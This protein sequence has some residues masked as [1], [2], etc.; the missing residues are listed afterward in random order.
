MSLTRYYAATATGDESGVDANNAALITAFNNDVTFVYLNGGD[1]FTLTNDAINSRIAI[2][3]IRLYG[4]GTGTP[5]L[6]ITG[7]EVTGGIIRV[8]TGGVSIILDDGT[9]FGPNMTVDIGSAG[10]LRPAT[11]T[12][13]LVTAAGAA[14]FNFNHTSGTLGPMGELVDGHDATTAPPTVEKCSLGAFVTVETKTLSV[15]SN[16]DASISATVNGNTT[17]SE[18]LVLG[19]NSTCNANVNNAAESTFSIARI[20]GNAT[21][22]LNARFSVSVGNS[23]VAAVA[24]TPFITLSGDRTIPLDLEASD[25]NGKYTGVFCHWPNLDFSL[26]DSTAQIFQ[27]TTLGAAAFSRAR[28]DAF[29]K[30]GH[31]ADQKLKKVGG[32]NADDEA[33]TWGYQMVMAHG[34]PGTTVQRQATFAVDDAYSVLSGIWEHVRDLDGSDP[35]VEN[36]TGASE[37]ALFG[38]SQTAASSVVWPANMI[39]YPMEVTVSFEAQGFSTG[40]YDYDVLV[41]VEGANVSEI[42]GSSAYRIPVH[43]TQTFDISAPTDGGDGVPTAS[44]DLTGNTGFTAAGDDGFTAS[45]AENTAHSIAYEVTQSSNLLADSYEVVLASTATGKTAGRGAATVSNGL[46]GTLVQTGDTGSFAISAYND[47]YDDGSATDDAV[48]RSFSL[49]LKLKDTFGGDVLSVRNV[50]VNYTD[51]DGFAPNYKR[52]GAVAD[53]PGVSTFTGEEPF[54]NALTDYDTTLGYRVMPLLNAGF[55]GTAAPTSIKWVRRDD[56]SEA[57]YGA[58]SK[59][60][61]QGTDTSKPVVFGTYWRPAHAVA[62]ASTAPKAHGYVQVGVQV[63]GFGT[64][65]AIGWRP[66]SIRVLSV[67]NTDPADPTDPAD[68][69][70]DAG[71]FTSANDWIQKAD[72][73]AFTRTDFTGSASA[74]GHSARVQFR[75]PANTDLSAYYLVLFEM[76]ATDAAGVAQTWDA[77]TGQKSGNLRVWIEAVEDANDQLAAYDFD[78]VAPKTF[79]WHVQPNIFVSQFQIDG[80]S[81]TLRY[82]L[83]NYTKNTAALAA[84]NDSTNLITLA[85]EESWPEIAT[86]LSSA[87]Q[88]VKFGYR[89]I[90]HGFANPTIHTFIETKSEANVL[91][92]TVSALTSAN[93]DVTQ[94]GVSWPVANDVFGSAEDGDTSDNWATRTSFDTSGDYKVATYTIPS[95]ALRRPKAEFTL[96][97]RTADHTIGVDSYTEKSSWAAQFTVVTNVGAGVLSRADRPDASY[98]GGAVTGNASLNTGAVAVRNTDV[99]PRFQFRLNGHPLTNG[100]PSDGNNGA[101]TFKLYV[102]TTA[103]STTS[104]APSGAQTLTLNEEAVIKTNSGDIRLA[105]GNDDWE[106]KADY[107]TDLVSDAVQITSANYTSYV[108]AGLDLTGMTGTLPS[109]LQ[110]WLVAQGIP[111]N[112]PYARPGVSGST[113]IE[114]STATDTFYNGWKVAEY[115]LTGLTHAVEVGEWTALSRPNIGNDFRWIVEGDALSLQYATYKDGTYQWVT[116]SKYDPFSTNSLW[117]AGTATT[118]GRFAAQSATAT[119][120]VANSVGNVNGLAEHRARYRV[121]RTAT[122]NSGVW[123]MYNVEEPVIYIRGADD[124]YYKMLKASDQ[125]ALAGEVGV[126]RYLIVD[127][128]DANVHTA[129]P[130]SSV[131]AVGD[132]ASFDKEILTP[133]PQPASFEVAP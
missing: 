83:N 92:S 36:A 39:H 54:T 53:V 112:S 11:A 67:P 14:T 30:V 76:E 79:K 45:V 28:F 114:L 64:D 21:G 46:P 93:T 25:P 61:E 5:T 128:G 49:T 108:T 62:G 111:S 119:V 91:I 102:G 107:V 15:A 8:Y 124:V 68:L 101:V 48:Y 10:N 78:A 104:G 70:A 117:Q 35:P 106:E 32:D 51:D 98:D 77:T 105:T 65:A 55:D 89:G 131:S 127:S 121:R 94:D 110:V 123:D 29:Q 103:D 1:S 52:L 84:Q 3:N 90:G 120:A 73:V 12:S 88:T 33:S 17:T 7:G 60:E 59:G 4:F 43:I 100:T 130:W 22:G 115:D 113:Y 132:E 72:G 37:V 71:T 40:D 44:L 58:G 23:S 109:N 81:E 75:I 41:T 87:D 95:A 125:S 57:P 16:Q 69:L 133:V 63:D 96:D 97:L 34:N 27:C 9:F 24:G 122:G 80:E 13:G 56:T 99:M 6:T 2:G 42:S 31:G 19:G 116:G 118:T 18:V 86:T 66:S 38:S 82:A 129:N 85:T 20:H 74:T 50:T 126:Y 26:V 47:D